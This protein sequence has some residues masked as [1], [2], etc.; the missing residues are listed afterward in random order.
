MLT[1]SFIKGVRIPSKNQVH[2][3]KHS[4]NGGLQLHVFSTGRKSWVL[5][6]RF[7]GTQRH[8]PLT[9]NIIPAEAFINDMQNAA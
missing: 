1:D 4:D 5:A 2:P 8:R 3:D 9:N 7:E 6:Y